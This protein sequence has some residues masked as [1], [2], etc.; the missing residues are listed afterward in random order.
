MHSYE[1]ERKSLTFEQNTTLSN[2]IFRGKFSPLYLRRMIVM[3]AENQ[4]WHFIGQAA[5]IEWS[6]TNIFCLD[7]VEGV[8]F[9]CVT[10]YTTWH[11]EIIL[12]ETN[13][14]ETCVLSCSD[15]NLLSKICQHSLKPLGLKEM[16]KLEPLNNVFFMW[17][18]YALK[19][20]VRC[21]QRTWVLYIKYKSKGHLILILTWKVGKVLNE[22]DK[23]L[24]LLESLCR[25]SQKEIT[26][27]FSHR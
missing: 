13:G 22:N 21:I 14:A 24:I 6:E 8:A 2:L 20:F 10:R 5:I 11:F 27:P 9:C 12:I 23:T 15:R 7:H 17:A 16:F 1:N 18:L 3:F 4:R 19:G 26:Y 25:I